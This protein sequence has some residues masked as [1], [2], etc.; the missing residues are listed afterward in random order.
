MDEGI[1]KI[2]K[3]VVDPE[4]DVNIVD[5]GL[6]YEAKKV[7]TQKVCIQMTL[8]SPTCPWQGMLQQLIK[9]ALK[10]NG[11]KLI[12]IEITFDSPWNPKRISKEARLKLGL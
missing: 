9:E 8:T 1:L 12:K 4:L 11:F 5:L 2:L 7:T 6:I 3:T 10:Q